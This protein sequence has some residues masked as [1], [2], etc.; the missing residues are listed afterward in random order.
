[1]EAPTIVKTL[2]Y[3]ERFNVGERVAS[4]LD[5]TI[6]NRQAYDIVYPNHKAYYN[7]KRFV[8]FDK[9]F[10]QVESYL[11]DQFKSAIDSA[12][13]Y[14]SNSNLVHVDEFD[15]TKVNFKGMNLQ[16]NAPYINKEAVQT[17]IN[18]DK[19][20]VND[21]NL[22]ISSSDPYTTIFGKYSN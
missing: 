3:Q 16:N 11:L 14:K 9:N 13:D 15:K 12:I 6:T 21:P 19:I 8:V 17:S 5:Q 7:D 22:K 4:Q 1:M 10:N 2:G 20:D 18:L